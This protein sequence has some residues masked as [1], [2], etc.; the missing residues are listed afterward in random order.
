MYKSLKFNKGD[1]C[2]EKKHVNG[3][4]QIVPLLHFQLTPSSDCNVASCLDFSDFILYLSIVASR[5]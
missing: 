1:L 5:N 3:T 2:M 4:E